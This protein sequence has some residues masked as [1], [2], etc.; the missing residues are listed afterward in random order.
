M[1]DF[2]KNYCKVVTGN[3]VWNQCKS[4]LSNIK[5]NENIRLIY[6]TDIPSLI[7][8]TKNNLEKKLYISTNKSCLKL[9]VILMTRSR[10][11]KTVLI[12]EFHE[13]IIAE[14]HVNVITAE[15]LDILRMIYNNLNTILCKEYI[16][17]WL[18]SSTE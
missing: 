9:P 18:R 12:E 1:S 10:N 3:I 4:D 15:S 6:S 8:K 14:N 13:P 2:I 11:P 5:T 7:I 16:K 17:K